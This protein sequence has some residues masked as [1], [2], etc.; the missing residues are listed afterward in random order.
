VALNTQPLTATGDLLCADKSIAT[1]TAA[2]CNYT[3]GD[4]HGVFC[5]C[6]SF[7]HS[8]FVIYFHF[9]PFV[10]RIPWL[11][12]V[13]A[14]LACWGAVAE[15]FVRPIK[16][17]SPIHSRLPEQLSWGVLQVDAFTAE[18][19]TPEVFACPSRRL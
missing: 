4:A 9:F 6:F 10:P 5:S 3:G 16:H 15:G 8:Y 11:P 19:F 1:F 12:F 2:A 17:A 7:C 14:Q 13:V 18:R